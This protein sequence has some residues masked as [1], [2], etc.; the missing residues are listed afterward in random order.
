MKNAAVM[1]SA[2]IKKSSGVMRFISKNMI[3]IALLVLCALLSVLTD[4][5][6]TPSN[7]WNIL[8]QNTT[9]GIVAVGMTFV[10][11]TGG[12]DLSVGSVVALCSALGAG[13]MKS[14]V[15]WGYA[16][17]GMI[18]IGT[19]IGCGQGLLIS[20]VK[21]PSFIVT[22]GMMGIARGMTMVYMQGMTISG[23]PQNMQFIGNGYIGG[24]I[25]CA[26]VILIAVFLIGFY[27]LKYTTFGRALYSLGGNREATELSGIN[28]KRVENL[29]YLFNGM[30]CG[31]GAII[32][33]ARLGSAITTAGEGLEMDVIGAT[34]I[35]GASL[36]GGRGTMFGTFVGVLILGVLNNGMNML[37]IDPFFSN[38]LRG[39]V[40]IIAVLIDTLRKRG[41]IG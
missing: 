13:M 35:G 38:A 5:F 30:A 15:P 34:V 12:I 19:G 18:A 24:V 27:M 9:V 22:L 26:A 8:I 40:I 25:P 31:I 1:A 32:L 4:R 17:V 3:F 39:I 2:E 33:T 23:L 36:A 11:I 10:I 16:I 20:R 28:V 7:L 29:A 6:L 21:M 37:N 41:E 14:G